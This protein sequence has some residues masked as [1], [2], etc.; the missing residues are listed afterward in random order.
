MATLKNF[1][2]GKFV[3]ATATSTVPAINPATEEVIARVPVSTA[4]DVDAA[5]QAATSV[6]PDWSGITIKQVPNRSLQLLS[7]SLLIRVYREL[8]SCFA[9]TH[10]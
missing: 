2:N 5:V 7:F 6:F 9:S 10:W 3:D 8:P 4:A 1:I